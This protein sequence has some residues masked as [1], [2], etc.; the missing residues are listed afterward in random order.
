VGR[1]LAWTAIAALGGIGAAGQEDLPQ[2]LQLPNPSFEETAGDRPAGWTTKSW[3]GAPTFEYA[4]AGHAGS[5]S[6]SV[7]SDSG[8][9]SAWQ[10]T[11]PVR[12]F[13]RYRLSGWIR[14]ENVVATTGRGALINVH[15]L[16]GAQTAAVTGTQDWTRVSVEFEVAGTDALEINCLLGGWGLATGRAWYDDLKLEQLSAKE[17][18]PAVNIDAAKTGHP[19]SKYIY[20]QFIEHLGRCIYGGIWAEMIED[21][22]FFYPVGAG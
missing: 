10:A 5:R 22:K 16:Q 4:S 8:A 21:R 18:K 12:P 20:G 17:L 13:A 7:A 11:V 1:F 14:T 19:I 9:D 15:A 3:Q 2:A 6:V